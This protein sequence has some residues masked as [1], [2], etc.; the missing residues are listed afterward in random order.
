MADD[1]EPAP[2]KIS[3]ASGGAPWRY[4]ASRR[5]ASLLCAECSARAREAPLEARAREAAVDQRHLCRDLI[6][7][8]ARAGD[9]GVVRVD[10]V[11]HLALVRVSVTEPMVAAFAPFVLETQVAA[12]ASAATPASRARLSRACGGTA[13]R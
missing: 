4:H 2:R 8:H 11:Q 1:S 7:R 13:E 3:T 6:S 9:R 12:T 5:A 10:L